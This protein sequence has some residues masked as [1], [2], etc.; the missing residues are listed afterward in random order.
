MFVY[1]LNL[2][3][4]FLSKK[5]K[6]HKPP[7]L[8]KNILSEKCQSWNF[9]GIRFAPLL[10]LKTLEKRDEAGKVKATKHF[11]F[12]KKDEI[13]FP[14]SSSLKSRSLIYIFFSLFSPVRGYDACAL[15]F[16][17]DLYNFCIFTVIF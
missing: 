4:F 9:H 8:Q 16:L 2:G 14:L 1:F 13:L 6:T 15:Y 5:K 12:L 7:V 10:L 11:H 3:F 17:I